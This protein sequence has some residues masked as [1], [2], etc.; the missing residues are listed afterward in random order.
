MPR[1]TSRLEHAAEELLRRKERVRSSE[2]LRVIHE[3]NQTGLELPEAT[4]RAQG[5]DPEPGAARIVAV[6]S[7]RAEW[8]GQ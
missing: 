3:I 8:R 7:A 2:L 5:P 4:A 1:P 6:T